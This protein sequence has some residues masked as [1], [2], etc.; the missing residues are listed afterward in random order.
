MTGE[1]LTVCDLLDLMIFLMETVT[2]V[3]VV[4]IVLFLSLVTFVALTWAVFSLIAHEGVEQR[5]CQE[6][7]EIGIYMVLG[8]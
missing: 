1:S 4:V 6:L 7:Q 2:V 3:V 8:G 5:I